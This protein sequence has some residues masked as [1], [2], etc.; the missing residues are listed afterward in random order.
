MADEE[1]FQFQ[2][3]RSIAVRGVEWSGMVKI[4][5]SVSGAFHWRVCPSSS[6]KSAKTF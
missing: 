6:S 3:N 2:S 4:E 5:E 1:I